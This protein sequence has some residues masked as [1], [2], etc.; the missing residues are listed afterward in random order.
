MS[1][2][3]HSILWL[4]VCLSVAGCQSVPV[5]SNP[6]AQ[7]ESSAVTGNRQAQL[8]LGRSLES[9][10]LVP[11]DIPGAIRW[12]SEAARAGSAEGAFGAGR[13][14]LQQGPERQEQAT[15]FIQSAAGYGYAP[16]QSMLAD[17][18]L[19]GNPDDVT[20]AERA[21]KLYLA[22]ADSALAEAQ[23][24]VAGL[25]LN[26]SGVERNLE[27]AIRW[28][29]RSA[30]QGHADAQLALGNVYLTGIGVAPSVAYALNW[31][32]KSA[33][34]GSYLAQS[35]MG[36][37]LTLERYGSL[38]DPDAGARWYKLSAEQN[39][40]HAQARLGNLYESGSG[41][42]RNLQ[43]AARWYLAAAEQG[44]ASAQCRLGSLYLR[45]LGVPQS[46]VEADR[47]FNRAAAQVPAGVLPLLGFIYYDCD[48]FD[49]HELRLD[50]QEI[51][52][53]PY[54]NPDVTVNRNSP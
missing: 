15:D 33:R 24:K 34:Q 30:E 8:D 18:I 23:F 1:L 45:G 26:G 16:A 29:R 48:Q 22:A 20:A 37:L 46:D 52:S 7:L 42:P 32:E 35:N 5:E 3:H 47:W 17:M 51:S 4:A 12:Y 54:S 53:S 49:R 13:L 28:Y 38:R 39:H 27:A 44:S 9:G 43:L 31:Y 40:A 21:Y 36:D 19:S 41:V 10:E 25:L 50:F 6:L 11:V 2:K 14:L